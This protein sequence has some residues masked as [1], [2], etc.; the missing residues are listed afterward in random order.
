MKLP[1]RRA[2]LPVV[3]GLLLL[4]LGLSSAWYVLHLQQQNSRI[5][6]VN[7]A[8]IRAAEE[9]EMIVR[10]MRYELDR[11]LLTENRIH[12]SQALRNQKDANRWL[13]Q[14]TELSRSGKEQRLVGDIKRG[15]DEYFVQL[16]QLVDD[17]NAQFSAEA[18]ERLEDETL[19]KQVLVAAH[20]YLDL[21]EQE[22]E[23]TDQLNQSMARNLAIGIAL[24]G[25]CGAI[26]GL[27]AGYSVARAINRTMFQLSVPIRD[28]AGKLEAVV[29]P[30][31]VA[32]DPS[33]QDLQSVLEVVSSRVG[34]VVDQLHERHHEVIRADQLAAVGKLGAGLAHELRNPLMCMR[35]LVQSARRSKDQA[36][37]NADDLAVLDEEITRMSGLLQKF[38]DFSRPGKLEFKRL[39]LTSIIRQ[40]VALVTSRAES[41]DITIDCQMPTESLATSGDETQIR[42]VLLNLLL[43]AFDAVPNGGK[44]AIELCDPGSENDG[45]A[46]TKKCFQLTVTDNG[47]GLPLER[48]RIF[49]PFF[50]TKDLGLGLG[51]PISKRI[52]EDHGGEL[53]GVNGDD[54]GAVFTVKLPPVADDSVDLTKG[55]ETCQNF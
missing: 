54:G 3:F 40:T 44:V 55:N 18:V 8:S 28:V 27:Q 50:S 31:S 26:F 22:L 49:E 7:V 4:S 43:N 25:T 45:K 36:I 19:S 13:E 6:N 42:Q 17:P 30:V 2:F 11:Y 20:R 41:R 34:T 15:L 21:N 48:N 37:L 39:E 9:L 46:D 32:A 14:A 53:I 29:G 1:S 35:T 51:L 52:I 10:E 5:L 33:E 16:H 24:L 23:Q 47:C 38:L 12:L